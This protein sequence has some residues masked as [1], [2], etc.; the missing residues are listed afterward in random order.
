MLYP[1]K[2]LFLPVL[3]ATLF[4]AP[5]A[6]QQ[7]QTPPANQDTWA[8]MER[9]HEE[10]K[11]GMDPD[12]TKAWVKMTIPDHQGLIDMSQVLLKYSKDSEIRKMA[13]KGIDE[14][15]KEIKRLQAWLAKHGG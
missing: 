8:A 15:S 6:T 7:A 10:M 4:S 1:F 12:P 2:F 14:Q 9:M 5:A 11:K 13:E 3:M